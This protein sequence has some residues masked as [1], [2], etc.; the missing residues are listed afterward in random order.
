MNPPQ[1]LPRHGGRRAPVESPHPMFRI[2]NHCVAKRIPGNNGQDQ[3]FFMTGARKRC[4]SN[5]DF[6]IKRT[7]AFWPQ[8]ASM[9]RNKRLFRDFWKK[10]GSE[11]VG[12]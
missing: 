5:P 2:G 4:V 11:G 7:I 3:W 10:Q 1:F 9:Q 6:V 12:S 8:I